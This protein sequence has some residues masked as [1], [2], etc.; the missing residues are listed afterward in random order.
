MINAPLPS[1]GNPVSHEHLTISFV[2]SVSQGFFNYLLVATSNF[3]VWQ[4]A[5]ASGYT[6]NNACQL[7]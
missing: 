7:S 3:V 5:R 1:P 2:Y 4:V 6:G